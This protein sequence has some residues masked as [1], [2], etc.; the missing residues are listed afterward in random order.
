MQEAIHNTL[1]RITTRLII[2]M[3]ILHTITYTT[4]HILR[5]RPQVIP[6]SGCQA[7]PPSHRRR[8]RSSSIRSSSMRQRQR[9]LLRLLP[10]F[11]E[12]MDRQLQLVWRTG[13]PTI[14]SLPL[15]PLPEV[16]EEEAEE[17][18]EEIKWW[19]QSRSRR[20]R[21]QPTRTQSPPPSRDL[22][23]LARR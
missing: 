21:H 17:A 13:W 11:L 2:I 10:L 7:I 14:R 6:P 9:L 20:R 15:P 5:H 16:V 4:I 23:K 8:I 3:R 22:P 19:R 12:T 1:L 18:E